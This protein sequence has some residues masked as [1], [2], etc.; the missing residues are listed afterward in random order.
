MELKVLQILPE[1]ESGGVERGV[2]E[3]STFLAEKGIESYVAS[4]GGSLVKTLKDHGVHHIKLPLKSKNPFVILWNSLRIKY[5]IEK[6]K[7]NIVHGRS[8]APAWSAYL[9]CIMTGARFVTTFHG[10]YDTSHPLKRFYNSVMLRGKIVIAVSNYIKKHIETR[11]HKI[12]K[13]VVVI[14]R[15][16]DLE[17]FDPSKINSRSIKEV[18]DQLQ[19]PNYEN[20]I[21]LPNR[22]SRHKGHIP[23]VNALNL[24]KKQKFTALI[25]GHCSENH[26]EY[27]REI[28][29]TIDDY[30][31]SDRVFIREKVSDMASLYSLASVVVC[32]SQVP[33]PFGRIIAES[34]AMGKVV[35]ATACG[36]HSEL[37][38]DGKTGYLCKVNDSYAMAEKI[39]VALKLSEP[40]RNEIVNAAKAEV[41]QKYTLER[42][43]KETLKVYKQLFKDYEEEFGDI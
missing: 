7:I 40:A 10:N 18:K 43:C 25:V 27:R 9:A 3:I 22:I 33:E 23:F 30:G 12:G 24:I 29:K 16:A 31:L 21:L 1:L 35:V 4:S 41:S 17:V 13:D 38:E 15:C 6:H 2:I 36:A 28:Q 26:I 14:H 5:Y 32:P 8:R 11:Y 37:I 42:M 20:L 19:L 39:E 34:F